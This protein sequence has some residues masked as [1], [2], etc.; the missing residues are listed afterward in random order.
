MIAALVKMKELISRPSWFL[1]VGQLSLDDDGDVA[2]GNILSVAAYSVADDETAIR[3][4]LA[5]TQVIDEVGERAL[6]VDGPQEY[7]LALVNAAISKEA[8]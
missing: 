1:T 2:I 8:S 5:L 7:V 3:I 4:A 6:F